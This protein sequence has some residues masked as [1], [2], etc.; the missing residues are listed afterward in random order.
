MGRWICA[1]LALSAA[2]AGC[3]E[4]SITARC[5]EI[6]SEQCSLC[7]G[8]AV[9]GWPGASL[10][11]LD[12]GTSRSECVTTLTDRCDDQVGARQLTDDGLDA[13]AAAYERWT[14]NDLLEGAAQ[15]LPANPIACR[16][17]F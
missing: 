2:S 16:R 17:F 9:E 10:C 12:E 1:V 13:C 5:E 3:L 11:E 4:S 14:C 8:C 15:D 7:Y 6:V